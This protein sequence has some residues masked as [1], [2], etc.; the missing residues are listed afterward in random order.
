MPVVVAQHDSGPNPASDERGV[1]H[2][3]NRRS[4]IALVDEQLGLQQ[5]MAI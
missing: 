1:V 4:L 2:S 3:H 5:V